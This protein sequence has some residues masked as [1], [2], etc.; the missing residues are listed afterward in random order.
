M[1]L[2]RAGGRKFIV[3]MSVLISATAL[4][5]F[6]KIDQSIYSSVVL[7]VVAAYLTANVVQ[8]RQA[9]QSPPG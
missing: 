1:S 2:D 7:A 8:K 4:V 3:A 5:V 9:Q 6:G